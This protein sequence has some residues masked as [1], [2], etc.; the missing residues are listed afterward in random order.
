MA[1][2]VQLNSRHCAASSNRLRWY[3]IIHSLQMDCLGVPGAGYSAECTVVHMERESRCRLQW[4]RDA[5]PCQTSLLNLLIIHLH[6]S[7][8]AIFHNKIMNSWSFCMKIF[9]CHIH[10]FMPPAFCWFTMLL[11]MPLKGSSVNQ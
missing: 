9:L 10:S 1:V 4:S 5:G 6:K 3:Y 2:K 8:W 11:A 7:Y